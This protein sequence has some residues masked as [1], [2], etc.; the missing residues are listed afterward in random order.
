MFAPDDQAPLTVALVSDCYLP[1]AGGIEVQAHDLALQLVAAGHRVVVLTTTVGPD[2]VDGIRVV[3]IPVPKAQAAIPLLPAKTPL[4]P[5]VFRTVAQ[6]LAAER[7]DVAHFHGGILSPLAFKG[8][9]DAQAAGI[10]TVI[11]THCLWSYATPAF[12]LLDRRFRWSTWPVVFS[13]VSDVAATPIRRI[14]GPEVDVSILPNGI[15]VDNWAVADPEAFLARREARAA[16]D[17]DDGPFTVA[18]V[19]RLAARKRPLQLVA[20]L[21]RLH[22]ELAATGGPRL[23]AVI[24]GDGGMRRSVERAIAK[25]GLGDVIELVGRRTRDE[26]LAMYADVDAFVAPAKLESFGIAALEART[27][28]VPVVAMANTGVR[29]FVEHGREGLLATGDRDMVAHLLRLARDRELRLGIAKHNAYTRPLMDW[30]GVVA[31][32]V[33]AYRRAMALM[34]D[35]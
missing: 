5:S 4:A 3:R 24:V 9:A 30:S 32:N 8:A 18:A 27:A 22:E 33:A 13:A 21:G 28:G 16:G 35:R 34:S 29:E 11:T 19:M 17:D 6:V 31:M 20:M 15:D 2:E 14:A 1:D 7:V 26:I 12:S 10:P 23:R 25:R